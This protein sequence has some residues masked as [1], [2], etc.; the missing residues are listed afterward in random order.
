[1]ESNLALDKKCASTELAVIGGGI[2][3]TL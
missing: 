2:C 1:M 3:V